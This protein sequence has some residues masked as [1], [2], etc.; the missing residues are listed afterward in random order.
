MTVEGET[1]S[2]LATKL[3]LPVDVFEASLERYNSLVDSGVDEDFGKTVLSAK[4]ETGPYYAIQVSP[5]VH[6]TMGGLVVDTNSRVLNAAGEPIPGLFAAGEV[7]GGVHG[8]NRLAANAIT[9][10]LVFGRIAGR[11]AAQEQVF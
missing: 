1:P 9:D 10:I 8:T 11:N 6:H 4:F 7:T 2:E 3:D 5:A